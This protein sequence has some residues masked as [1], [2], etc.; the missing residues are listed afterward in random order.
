MKK[1]DTKTLLN[2]K[3]EIESTKTRVSELTG[4]K[5]AL[6]EQLINTFDCKDI[7]SAKKLLKQLMDNIQKQEA[8]IEKSLEDLKNKYNIEL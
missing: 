6:M 5:K 3:Q 2:L 4:Q 8:S 1:F 7:D